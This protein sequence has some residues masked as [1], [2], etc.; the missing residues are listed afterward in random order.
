VELAI[1]EALHLKSVFFWTKSI[2]DF[3]EKDLLE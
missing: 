2:K 1:K 3:G